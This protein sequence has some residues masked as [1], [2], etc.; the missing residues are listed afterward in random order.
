MNKCSG[1]MNHVAGHLQV[2]SRKCVQIDAAEPIPVRSR[3]ST[4]RNRSNSSAG[5]QAKSA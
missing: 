4:S 5:R 2:V 1:T 3:D